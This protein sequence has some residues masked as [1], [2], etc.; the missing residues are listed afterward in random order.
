MAYGLEVSADEVPFRLKLWLDR[1]FACARAIETFAVSTLKAKKRQ[2]ENTLADILNARPACEVA[3]ALRAKFARASPQ[4]LTFP[5]FPGQVE[6]TNNASERA[7]RP[8][9]IQRKN[10]NG[11]RSMWA[12][13][14]DCAVRTVTDTAK[15]TGQ[16]PYQTITAT[17]A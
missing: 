16:T 4:L 2:L 3:E 8:A 13:K 6:V 15:L 11:F 17:L 12:A 1:V 5:D 9:V 14:G 10:T 7:L